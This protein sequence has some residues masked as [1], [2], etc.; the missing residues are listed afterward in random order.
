[1]GLALVGVALCALLEVVHYRAHTRPDLSSFCSVGERFD[2]ASVALSGYAVWLGVPL[3]LWGGVGFALI[4]AAAWRRS[5]W[6]WPLALA[7]ALASLVLLA[8]ELLVL[9]S[10]CLLCEGVHALC[11]ALAFL[12][13]RAH[14][15][16]PAGPFSLMDTLM[17]HAPAAGVLLA[18]ALFLP[19]YW[20]AFDWRGALPYPQGTTA[21]GDAWIG[22]EQPKLTVLEFV[23]YTCP[24]CKAASAR[25]LRALA[26]HPDALRVVRAYYPRIR[27]DAAT[28]RCLPLRIA[29]CAGEQGKFWQADRYLFERVAWDRALQPATVAADLSLQATRFS[30]CLDRPDVFARAA[31]AWKRAKKLR[32]PGTP[33]YLVEGKK[34]A[35]PDVARAIHAL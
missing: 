8:L 9:G 34:M 19:R 1:M 7:A 18:L 10:V 11:F 16:E 5:F 31:A 2:C 24:H 35:E 25:S 3:P 27:C 32:L 13:W 29:A 14:T 6:T 20:S 30:E 17:L 23:D 12:A 15:R 4:G 21:D 22:A 26:R 33:Y 28:D